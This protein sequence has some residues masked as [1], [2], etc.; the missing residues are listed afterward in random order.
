MHKGFL[1][2]H[3]NL[4]KFLLK[5]EKKWKPHSLFGSGKIHFYGILYG[6][7]ENMF[8]FLTKLTWLQNIFMLRHAMQ[9]TFYQTSF[10]FADHFFLQNLTNTYSYVTRNCRY[11]KTSMEPRNRFQGID[12]ASLCS[13]AGRYENPFPTWFLAPIDCSKIPAQATEPG[14]IGSLE[15][16][17]GL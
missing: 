3:N 5:L 1:T 15:S 7:F 9:S 11:F 8:N 12:S 14:G 2:W 10:I 16:I 6:N 17:L 4:L 13:L